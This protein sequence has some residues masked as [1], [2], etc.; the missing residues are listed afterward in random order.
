MVSELE[1]LESAPGGLFLVGSGVD[2]APIKP[3]LESATSLEVSAPEEPETALARGAA[4]ASANAPMFA[5]STAALAYAQDPGT[6]AVDATPC[7]TTSCSARCRLGDDDFAYSAVPD[8]DADA[9]TVV[10]ERLVAGRANRVAGRCCWSVVGWRWS[11]LARCWRWR[12]HWRSASAR[13]LL[14]S[15][16]PTKTSSSQHSR[17]PH[18]R[19]SRRPRRS[20]KSARRHRW[21]RPSH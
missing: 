11:A 9:P 18:P 16:P 12:L 10:I 4:L 8:E 7:P 1:E 6:G 13:R 17:P 15:P 5:S 19:R 2:I 20:R 3:A 21:R 14:C